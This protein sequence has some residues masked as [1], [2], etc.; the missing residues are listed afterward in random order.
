M[1]FA[2]FTVLMCTYHEEVPEY[3]NECLDSINRQTARPSQLVL[4]C[5]GKLTFKL[6]EVISFWAE[7]LPITMVHYD[8]Q[9]KLG[10]A[11]NYGLQ[12]CEH[13]I[14]ARMDSD[15]ICFPD[16]FE[17]QLCAFD[18]SIDIMSTDIIEFANDISQT[19]GLRVV[20][21]T[22]NKKTISLKNPINHMAVMFRRDKITA[23]GGYLPLSG[24]EDWYLWLRAF[25]A[26]LVIRNLS[27]P[28]VYARVGN[29]FW[30]R[31]SGLKY[32]SNEI[33]ALYR[34][35]K[36]DLITTKFFV[37]GLLVRIPIRFLSAGI[38]SKVFS[39]I[40]RKYSNGD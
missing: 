10:G 29:G 16:R 37:I 21:R 38:G 34:F 33:L 13:E 11:L 9:G 19:V 36:D 39:I 18:A 7:Y 14:I 2:R 8:G 30:N 23:A 5:D 40:A 6:Y 32:A 24:F 1:N 25:K 12:F 26:G 17:R 15:D 28:S 4:V 31:R 3:L 22:V 20:P 27:G 35:W